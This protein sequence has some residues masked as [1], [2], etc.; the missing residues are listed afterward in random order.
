MALAK[1]PQKTVIPIAGMTCQACAVRV[2]KLLRQIPGVDQAKVSF[3]NGQA[4]I[5]S[6]QPPNRE[7]LDAAIRPAGYAIAASALPL[8]SRDR[9][10]WRDMLIGAILIGLI[11]WAASAFGLTGQSGL[12]S[13]TS[14]GSP[15]SLENQ[16]GLTSLIGRLG[17]ARP[18]GPAA[19]ALA[20]ALGA[21]ASIS[22]CMALVGGLVLSISARFAQRHPDLSP[23]RRLRPQVMFNLGRIIGF[24]LLG[25]L[26]GAIG[27]IFELSSHLLAF[28]MIGAAIVMLTLGVRLTGLSPRLSRISFALPSSWARWLPRAEQRATYSDW[29][30]LGLGAATFLL[31]CG[32][33]QAVQIYALASGDAIQ[34]GLIL[35]AFAIG[36]TPGLITIGAAG[37]LAKGPA[38][39]HIFRFAGAGVIAFALVNLSG[40]AHLLQ[41]GWFGPVSSVITTERSDNVVDDA[42]YQVLSTIQ[43]GRGYIPQIATVY[44]GRPVRWEIDSRGVACSSTINLGAI[45]LGTVHLQPGLNVFEFTA[46]DPG[47]LPY[48]CG[49]GMFA[50]QINVIAEPSNRTQETE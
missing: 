40:A 38:A 3:T 26:L 2:A 6:R 21:V 49:M 41:P 12:T 45:G 50:A 7:Q 33:T 11:F 17:A 4:T 24:G 42:A 32:F 44:A 16:T 30:T 22:T 19:W 43:D 48:S 13:Q 20:F 29:T 27:G 28:A 46:D 36:T 5:T 39:A 23:G 8:L 37:S 34:A 47:I 31:P 15:A 9:A 1:A 35:M 25:G 10:V 18:D 14:P